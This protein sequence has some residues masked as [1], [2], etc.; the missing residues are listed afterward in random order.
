MKLK[1]MEKKISEKRKYKEQFVSDALKLFNL[2]SDSSIKDIV[3]LV[4]QEW[5]VLDDQVSKE[6]Q[7]LDEL[8]YIWKELKRKIENLEQWLMATKNS[9]S[10]VGEVEP[11]ATLLLE[12]VETLVQC[13]EELDSREK[14][15]AQI[16]K[17][18]EAFDGR[19][20]SEEVDESVDRLEQLWSDVD[21][22]L[23][24]RMD[25]LYKLKKEVENGQVEELVCSLRDII[26]TV[27]K[28]CGK[29]EEQMFTCSSD[30]QLETSS[31][32]VC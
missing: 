18:K 31:L 8:L 23:V 7:E 27:E 29:H 9:V 21:K 30:L 32:E 24:T 10:S 17:M 11:K 25:L 26:T 15:K 1:D 13:R 28:A 6:R 4:N 20:L 5:K 2:T 3:D 14:E 22:M 12:Q 19:T 16:L